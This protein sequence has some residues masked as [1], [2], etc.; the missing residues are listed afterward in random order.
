MI[1]EIATQGQEYGMA[2][3]EWYWVVACQA[4]GSEY[5][6]AEG[7]CRMHCAE[8]ARAYLPG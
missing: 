1:A 2:D 4:Y 6:N 7:G 8:A 5:G 3:S